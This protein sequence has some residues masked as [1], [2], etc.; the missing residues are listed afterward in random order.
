MFDDTRFRRGLLLLLG[1]LSSCSQSC[2]PGLFHSAACCKATFGT[3]KGWPTRFSPSRAQL[4]M[5]T[6][7]LAGAYLLQVLNDASRFPRVSDALT[8]LERKRPGNLRAI[9]DFGPGLP[10]PCGTARIKCVEVCTFVDSNYSVV[11]NSRTNSSLWRRA[12]ES[13]TT[14]DGIDTCSAELSQFWRK[15][16]Q[17]NGTYL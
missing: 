8:R 14:S 6:I 13:H 5:L 10:N 3:E 15:H 1:T 16:S 4:L 9:A 12:H 17:R 11:D 7:V 2:S